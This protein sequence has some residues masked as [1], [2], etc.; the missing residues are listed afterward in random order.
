[1]QHGPQH[2]YELYFS[3]LEREKLNQS[4]TFDDVFREIF[5]ATHRNEPSFCSKL[6]ATIRPEM[7]VYDSYVREN[8]SLNTPR[9]HQPRETR[10]QGFLRAYSVL[11][12]TIAHLLTDQRYSQLKIAFD[13]K[14]PLYSHLTD[15]KKLDLVLWQY[16]KPNSGNSIA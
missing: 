12:E 3:L 2:W 16:R 6:V 13:E 1:M 7:P 9:P 5:R 14:Y 8:L 4:V 11:E 15:T 10:L